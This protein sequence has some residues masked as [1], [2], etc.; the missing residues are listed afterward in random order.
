MNFISKKTFVYAHTVCYMNKP[1][2]YAGAPILHSILQP[3]KLVIGKLVILV[4]VYTVKLGIIR[5]TEF[6]YQTFQHHNFVFKT[7]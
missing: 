3:V 2:Q 1:N 7:I 4:T 5:T 6:L